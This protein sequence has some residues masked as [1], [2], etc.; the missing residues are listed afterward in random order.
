M[1]AHHWKIQQKDHHHPSFLASGPAKARPLLSI[2]VT[3]AQDQSPSGEP[4]PEA[5][6]QARVSAQHGIP[7][8]ERRILPNSKFEFQKNGTGRSNDSL[9][10]QLSVRVNPPHPTPQPPQ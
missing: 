10:E 5:S 7:S 2:K 1:K 9:A 8:I 4:I 3:A 6:K